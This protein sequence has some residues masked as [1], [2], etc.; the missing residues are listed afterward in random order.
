M[1]GD[2]HAFGLSHASPKN[3]LPTFYRVA[4][5]KLTDAQIAHDRALAFR[6][7]DE[8]VS[9]AEVARRLKRTSGAISKWIK[10]RGKTQKA[11]ADALA[12]ELANPSLPLW[13]TAALQ[14]QVILR[15][16]VGDASILTSGRY[17]TWTMASIRHAFGTNFVIS[18]VDMHSDFVLGDIYDEPIDDTLLVRVLTA[19]RCTRD[20]D[21]VWRPP[22]VSV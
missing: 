1:R 7:L 12:Q 14:E 4:R 11:L 21:G 10:E 20:A 15:L 22:V 19:W 3:S 5:P 17:R 2:G 8:N 9:A 16:T 18:D 13:A 6:L